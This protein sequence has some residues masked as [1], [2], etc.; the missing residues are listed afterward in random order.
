LRNDLTS[1][2]FDDLQRGRLVLN[3]LETCRGFWGPSLTT[4]TS[5]KDK[6]RK[7]FLS[8]LLILLLSFLLLLL[9]LLLP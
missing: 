4:K 8:F 6:I 3:N 5:R 9:L 1:F 7:K 2:G